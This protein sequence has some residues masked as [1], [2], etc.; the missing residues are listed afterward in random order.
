[1][2]H[3]EKPQRDNVRSYWQWKRRK[4]KMSNLNY[5][6][7]KDIAL[8]NIFQ[9]GILIRI[10][11]R[12]IWDM[13]CWQKNCKTHLKK[14]S[15]PAKY[16]PELVH[17]LRT[18]YMSSHKTV[19]NGLDNDCDGRDRIM[20]MIKNFKYFISN[21]ILMSKIQ[22]VRQIWYQI[23]INPTWLKY[24]GYMYVPGT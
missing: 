9:K 18:A 15:Y 12:S 13:L 5:I 10:W 17:W 7:L 2:P 22:Y 16:N 1:M 20:F 14:N 23:F 4:S 8:I 19:G 11:S 21:N 6:E 24:S 3:E